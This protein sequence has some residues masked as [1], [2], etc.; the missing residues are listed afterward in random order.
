MLSVYHG[1]DSF[2]RRIIG[3]YC[4]AAG[5]PVALTNGLS[6]PIESFAIHGGVELWSYDEA[7][8][9]LVC[10]PQLARLNQGVKQTL[11]LTFQNGASLQCTPNHRLMT[12]S[13]SWIEAKDVI[14]GNTRLQMGILS[15][16][17]SVQLDEAGWSLNCKGQTFGMS[18]DMERN[19]TMAFCRILGALLSDGTMDAK[20]HDIRLLVTHS[21]DVDA[22]KSDLKLIDDSASVTTYQKDEKRCYIRVGA[23]IRQAIASLGCIT[24][25]R[26]VCQPCKWPSFL[27]EKSC[28]KALVREFVGG[29]F[30]SDGHAPAYNRQGPR[31]SVV[32]KPVAFS[33]SCCPSLHT[34]L[35]SALQQ[36]I[37]LLAKAGVPGAFIHCISKNVPYHIN[38]HGK[39]PLAYQCGC[40]HHLLYE[41]RV[42]SAISNADRFGACIGFRYSVNK[43]MRLSGY[44]AFITYQQSIA[45]QRK[46]VLE[47]A[48]ALI[49]NDGLSHG[50]ALQQ[51]VSELEARETILNDHHVRASVEVVRAV[52][53][54]GQSMEMSDFKCRNQSAL[55]G[56]QFAQECGFGSWFADE[57]NHRAG[58]VAEAVPCEQQH[59]PTYHLRVVSVEDAGAQPVYDLTC[60][61]KTPSFVAGG[62]IAH[63]CRW[64][65]ML[66]IM[67]L[68]HL[69]FIINLIEMAR[70]TGVPIGYLLY[71]G[72]QVKVVSLILRAIYEMDLVFP[73]HKVDNDVEQEK[74]KGATV[75]TALSGYYDVPIATLDFASLYPSI[76]SGIHTHTHTQLIC[77]FAF[78]FRVLTRVLLSSI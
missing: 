65:A 71:R 31:Q 10:G 63:N 3:D 19:R 28:P 30:G 51:A 36:L 35:E 23:S 38:K 47:R 60:S 42:P 45:R 78:H 33:R 7:R 53:Y 11:R 21:L 50:K 8:G 68:R 14:S 56:L 18:N 25:G 49:R 1:M 58:V 6:L 66:P 77:V 4:I 73:Y 17:D 61:D 62:V 22:I 26:R 20:T 37:E 41:I 70:A 32:F 52:L 34:E 57:T 69:K 16:L 72:Q 27:L 48:V 64:D 29:L 55:D 76:M 15:V 54:K 12:D 67:L 39:R 75:L 40:D 13:G 9:G 43:Q 24:M 74:Y 2:H 59:L 5:T 44:Q 46:I